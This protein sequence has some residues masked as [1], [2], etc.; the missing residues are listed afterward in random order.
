MNTD[1]FEKRLQRQQPREIPPD[2]RTDILSA[3][4]GA[5][6]PAPRS[7]LHAP[8]SFLS[9]LNHHLSAL[10]WP[11][12]RAWAGLAAVWLGLLVVNFGTASKR[13]AV[14]ERTAQTFMALQ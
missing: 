9:T 3:A 14:A 6:R 2:W 5:A 4:R 7:T 12:P 1:D 11:S 8:R 10:L 13:P